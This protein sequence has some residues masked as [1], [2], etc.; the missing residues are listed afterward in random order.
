MGHIGRLE[1]DLQSPNVGNLR[2]KLLSSRL[3]VLGPVHKGIRNALSSL[4]FA[5]GRVDFS[6]FN[7][8]IIRPL[9]DELQTLWKILHVHA[10]VEDKF[11]FPLVHDVDS[12]LFTQLN[13]EHTSMDPIMD[14][15]ENL[16][17]MLRTKSETVTI[18]GIEFVRKLNNFIALYFV[19]LMREELEIL[20][21]LWDHYDDKKLM[22]A[23]SKMSGASPPELAMNFLKYYL[24]AVNES[25]RAT[26]LAGMKN[27]VP[28]AAFKGIKD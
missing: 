22:E 2:L 3:D 5:F 20:P 28:K 13:S 17:G 6:K 10:E 24:P 26:F 21:Q 9:C 12:E 18:T 4:A 1:P 16:A 19:H 27:R 11:L 23:A 8:S 14:E 15:I 7:P 25:E